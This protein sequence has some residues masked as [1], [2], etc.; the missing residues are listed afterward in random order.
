MSEA[1]ESY[2]QDADI[3]MGETE[4]IGVGASAFAPAVHPPLVVKPPHIRPTAQKRSEGRSP[5]R[6]NQSR[7]GCDEIRPR[8]RHPIT[9]PAHTA[10][11]PS[12]NLLAHTNPPDRKRSI[13]ARTP[14]RAQALHRSKAQPHHHPAKR[15]TDSSKTKLAASDARQ[16][17]HEPKHSSTPPTPAQGTPPHT[18]DHEGPPPG[19]LLI[20][21]K[22]TTPET[23]SCPPTA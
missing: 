13:K 2:A 3:R 21:T 14:T 20:G 1:E 15:P 22:Q 16:H 17:P 9:M 8:K 12:H 6:R 4:E 23:T 19:H 10:P 5:Q 11:A 18:R 7:S